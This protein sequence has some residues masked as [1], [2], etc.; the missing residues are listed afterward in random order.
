MLRDLD[1]GSNKP[2]LATYKAAKAM[3]TGVAVV[4]DDSKGT[5][6][7]PAAATGA[8]LYFVDKERIPT[9]YKA[10]IKNISDYDE[11]YVTVEKGELAK[12]KKYVTG[13]VFATDAAGTPTENNTV[14][15]GS[16]G[17]ITDSAKGSIYLYVGEY[18]DAGNHTLKKIRVLDTARANS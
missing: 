5:F 9:G 17:S 13:D 2:V 16:D 1:Y 12:L 8:N 18:K 11:D 15:F 7:Y 14:D 4:I 6:D 3:K 10:G